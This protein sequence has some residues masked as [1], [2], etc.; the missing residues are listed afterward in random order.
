MD[1]APSHG[2]GSLG[3]LARLSS[4]LLFVD[5]GAEV[6]L[7]HLVRGTCVRVGRETHGELLHFRGFQEVSGRHARWLEEG[8]LVQPFQDTLEAHGGLRPETEA[9]LARDYQDWYWRREVESEREYRWLGHSIVK[10]P[11]DLF[12]YQELLVHQGLRGV[13]EV[14]Y[15]SG[16][17]LWFF[18][19][20]LALQGGGDVV[21][22]D[23]ERCEEPPPFTRFA[24]VRVER[25]HGCAHEERTVQAVRAL[26]PEGFGLVV[27]DADPMPEGKLA[28]LRRWASLVG[29]GGYLV[30]E[31]T[32]S[33][34]CR[35]APETLGVGVDRFLLDHRDFGVA[36]EAARFPLLKS[37]GTVFRRLP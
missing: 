25:V 34:E 20:I 6:E 1:R 12:F 9:Q 18:A 22:V 35:E 11:S 32:D 36:V 3:Q 16:G 2:K 13:L 28:L 8:V 7:Q 19:S 4:H 10:M 21:G 37:R 14:G 31:D 17:G 26:R 23:R 24:D 15:G 5:H 29:P 27:L 33:P 30:L